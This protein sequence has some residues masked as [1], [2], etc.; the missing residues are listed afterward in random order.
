MFGK[1]NKG[2]FYVCVAEETETAPLFHMMEI[3][4]H[5]LVDIVYKRGDNPEDGWAKL[6]RIASGEQHVLDQA[7]ID[8]VLALELDWRSQAA[9]ELQAKLQGERG[10]GTFTVSVCDER[11]MEHLRLASDTYVRSVTWALDSIIEF[12]RHGK[13]AI[14]PTPCIKRFARWARRTFVGEDGN[15]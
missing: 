2:Q 1:P 10:S 13:T 7:A 9:S 14:K 3:E 4:P 12:R 8:R 15:Y 5:Q 6:Q 11:R